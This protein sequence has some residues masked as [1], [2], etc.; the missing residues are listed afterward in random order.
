MA[1]TEE[2]K[3]KRRRAYMKA[4]NKKYRE[5][6]KAKCKR[7]TA[8]WRKNNR[9]KVYKHKADWRKNNPETAHRGY[10]RRRRRNIAELTDLHIKGVLTA[11][12]K[13]KNK[14]LPQSLIQAKRA[15]LKLLRLIKE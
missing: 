6:N 11:R 15:E 7:L 9:D 10:N 12:T 4:Y 14:D 13:L 5:E 1:L 3:R 8:E 2:E